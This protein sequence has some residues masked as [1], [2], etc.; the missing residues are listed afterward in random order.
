MADGNALIAALRSATPS[1]MV[2]APG[3]PTTFEAPP[4]TNVSR[5]P[6]SAVLSPETPFVPVESWRDTANLEPAFSGYTAPGYSPPEG[7]VPDPV[8]VAPQ[9][10]LHRLQAY[11][12]MNLLALIFGTI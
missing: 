5:Q 3:A 10:R 11:N 2:K 8:V 6:L 9:R 12:N 7:F 1:G 4:W